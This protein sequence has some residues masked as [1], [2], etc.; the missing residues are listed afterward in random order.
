MVPIEWRG[1][2]GRGPDK[3]P[4]EGVWLSQAPSSALG[5]TLFA[6]LTLLCKEAPGK[7]PHLSTPPT[8]GALKQRQWM[9][10][11]GL[12]WV[13]QPHQMMLCAECLPCITSADPLNLAGQV[14]HCLCLTVEEHE[15]QTDQARN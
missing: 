3:E 9:P 5:A 11:A 12:G 14:V 7:G 4:P 2:E 13:Q 6:F 15:I 10:R 8:A 1:S